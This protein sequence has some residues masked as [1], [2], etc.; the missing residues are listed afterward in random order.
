MSMLSWQ[1]TVWIHVPNYTQHPWMK[2]AVPQNDD[3][4]EINTSFLFSLQ[5]VF[6][7]LVTYSKRGI[8]TYCVLYLKQ[9]HMLP[10]KVKTVELLEFE[11]PPWAVKLLLC[12]PHFLHL[13]HHRSIPSHHLQ[14]YED[15]HWNLGLSG[16]AQ[17]RVKQTVST[18]NLF[19][20]T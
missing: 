2:P 5:S 3:R 19:Q 1:Q 15:V 16:P 6:S 10:R 7:P 9:H 17:H 20:E 13:V 12:L 14:S 4:R 18:V 8:I 11:D